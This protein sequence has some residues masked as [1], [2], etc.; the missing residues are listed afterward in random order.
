MD[1]DSFV[2]LFT[3][4]FTDFINLEGAQFEILVFEYIARNCGFRLLFTC[5][6]R[7]LLLNFQL[8]PS[9]KEHFFREF[10]DSDRLATLVT[11][12]GEWEVPITQLRLTRMLLLRGNEWASFAIANR[13]EERT[14]MRFTPIQGGFFVDFIGPNGLETPLPRRKP[15][16]S[17]TVAR[18]CFD[19]E[20]VM[21]DA[22]TS[23]TII[24]RQADI[25]HLKLVINSFLIN[26]LIYCCV[27]L[28]GDS[29]SCA[30]IPYYPVDSGRFLACTWAV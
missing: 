30:S 20:H 26:P 15:D 1:R 11:T 2:S 10:F 28:F 18:Q 25:W 24:N 21:A 13:C 19:N 14:R 23:F 3:F 12:R 17:F 6:F 29:F 5:R 22:A 27:L 4:T 7:I 8:I 16:P 9:D